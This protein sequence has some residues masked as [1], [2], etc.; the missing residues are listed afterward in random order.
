MLAGL[1]QLMGTSLRRRVCCN[2][3]MRALTTGGTLMQTN[4]RAP[5]PPVCPL[6]WFACFIVALVVNGAVMLHEIDLRIQSLVA[7]G[8]DD[9]LIAAVQ[10]QPPRLDVVAQA[11]IEHFI[12][13]VA[14]QARVFDGHEN[15][16]AAVEVAL[17]PVG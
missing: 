16:D 9:A 6:A 17:H 11:D 5:S 12:F 1:T 10:E 7:F 8:A 15:F 14:L 4:V 2:A 3:S 13:Q